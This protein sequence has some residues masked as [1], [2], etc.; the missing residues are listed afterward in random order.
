MERVDERD[1]YTERG[2][3]A[4]NG[5]K[6]VAEKTLTA[7]RQRVGN[8]DYVPLGSRLVHATGNLAVGRVVGPL[9][10][11]VA[12]D[13]HVTLL[14]DRVDELIREHT[15]TRKRGRRGEETD[16]ERR[17]VEGEADSRER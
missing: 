8:C 13:P 17:K 3:I 12:T 7:D 9:H 2:R 4:E 5:G 14:G 6:R 1:K 11:A 15:G 10:A 16:E